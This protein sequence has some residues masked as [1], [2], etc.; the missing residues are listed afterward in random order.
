VTVVQPGVHADEASEL[1]IGL[2]RDHVLEPV[3][4]ERG[5]ASQSDPRP[6]VHHVEPRQPLGPAMPPQQANCG[7]EGQ[8]LGVVSPVDEERAAETTIPRWDDELPE[9]GLGDQERRDGASAL[10][11]VGAFAADGHVYRSSSF[12]MV[13]GCPSN[14]RYDSWV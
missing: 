10:I 12:A 4:R 13:N 11:E 2:E 14:G 6:G 8:E 5:D 3:K 9:L 7:P 1:H